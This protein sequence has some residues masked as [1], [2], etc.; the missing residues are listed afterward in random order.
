MCAG[1]L[2][3]FPRGTAHATAYIEDLVVFADADYVGEIVLVAGDG[4]GKG[5]AGTEAAE[6][7]GLGPAVFV[8][9]GCE[10]V[11]L[12]GYGGVVCFAGLENRRGWSWLV[13]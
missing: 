13:K 1:E 3:D 12:A 7:E 9:I 2:G 8:E 10:V 4:G 6:M 11:V 5:L